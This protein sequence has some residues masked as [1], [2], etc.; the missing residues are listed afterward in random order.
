MNDVIVLQA[1]QSTVVIE[2]APQPTVVIETGFRGMQGP[3]VGGIAL[4]PTNNNLFV[5]YGGVG[6]NTPPNQRNVVIGTG[7]LGGV[8][9][10]FTAKST[11]GRY[12][13]MCQGNVAIGYGA[14]QHANPYPLVP[15][16][17]PAQYAQINYSVAIGYRALGTARGS[18]QN[19]ALGESALA[20][21]QYGSLNIAIGANAMRKAA[22]GST[23]DL[24]MFRCVG[25]GADAMYYNSGSDNIGI[26]YGAG[27][28]WT[29]TAARSNVA[30]GTAAGSIAAGSMWSATTNPD[31]SVFV[32][33]KACP[34]G[35]G[36]H[37]E[38]VIGYRAVG[39]GANTATVG[40]SSVVDTFLNGRVH[41]TGAL[42][43][44][45]SSLAAAPAPS[46]EP[47]GFRNINGIVDGWAPCWSNGTQWINLLK[48]AVMA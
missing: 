1:P 33:F 21:M 24:Q 18:N 43:A 39:G 17:S 27:A 29:S 14:M 30:I 10:S 9:G 32:G 38:I 2:Q 13:R 37:N 11:Y 6:Q 36:S 34:L 48:S 15:T 47:Y 4:S 45:S 16:A 25:I 20:G 42:I 23:Y 31:C 12:L 22:A 44:P 7:A 41:S 3:A 19:F 5:G 40:N 8:T 35:A 26:G 28:R 46:S